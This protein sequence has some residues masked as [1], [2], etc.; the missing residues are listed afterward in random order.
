MYNFDPAQ[1]QQIGRGLGNAFGYGPRGRQRQMWQQF[2]GPQSQAGWQMGTTTRQ[3]QQFPQM[4]QFLQGL[5][6]FRR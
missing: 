5:N 3:P 4:A 1:F 6:P 2:L